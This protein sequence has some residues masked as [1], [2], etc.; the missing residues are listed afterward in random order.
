MANIMP[1][2]SCTHDAKD[3][4]HARTIINDLLMIKAII[5]LQNS[6]HLLSI[7][8]NQDYAQ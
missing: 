8:K 3:K 5:Y 7:S 1:M 2:S 6:I 4:T